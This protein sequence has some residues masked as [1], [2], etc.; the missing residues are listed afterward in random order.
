M[1]FLRRAMGG[2]FLLALTLGLLTWG[3]R[4]VW[5]AVAQAMA[6]AEPAEA[7]RERRFSVELVTVTPGTL[8]P[9]LTTYGQVRPT[10]ILD[11]RSPGSGRVVELAPGFADGAAV[12]AGQVLLRLDPADRQAARDLAHSDVATA[13]AELRGADQALP[14]TRDE[15]AGAGA[16]AALRQTALQRQRDLV[17]RG[18]GT[19][20]LV[21]EAELAQ[22][23]AA[24]AVLSARAALAT[25]Q[26][27]RD[28]TAAALDRARI[29]AAEADR[30]LADTTLRAAFSGSLAAVA[31]MEGGLVSANERLAQIIDPAALEVSFRLS[32]AHYARL[33]GPDGA[34]LPTDLTVSLDIGS[35]DIATT[36]T[37]VRVGAEVGEGQ[38]GRLIYARLDLARGFRPG[39]FVTVRLVEPPL[40]GVAMLPAA[41]VGSD[42]AV[43]A[44]A[45]GDRL[46]A[47]PVTVLRRQGDQ[48]IV[49]AGALAG[50]EV[51]AERTPLLGQGVAVTP[52]RPDAPQDQAPRD[53]AADAGDTTVALSPERRAE[54]VARVEADGKLPADAKARLLAELRA[55]RV[56]AATIA[57]LT[58]PIGG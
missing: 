46:E 29:A 54:L 35:A 6:P 31:V 38:T 45:G 43:L 8:I 17:A 26:S 58:A 21:Q 18:A 34:L 51:V 9:E 23:A 16:Q 7:A 52:R 10:R 56:P 48:V 3:G 41:A 40:A 19:E 22:N 20:A 50:R 11:L 5:L 13:E 14:L 2:L 12:T 53:Q 15:L 33:L 28:L 39:D 44:L 42:G 4:A 1:R 36:G 49:A 32:T 55:D 30:A 47:L 24:Q 27:R 57:R 37:V 25:A